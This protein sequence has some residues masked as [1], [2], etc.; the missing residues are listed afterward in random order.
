[1]IFKHEKFYTHI[2]NSKKELTWH[3][4]DMYGQTQIADWFYW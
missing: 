4:K 3:I 1:M 2:E